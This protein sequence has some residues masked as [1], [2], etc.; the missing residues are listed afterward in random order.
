MVN[1]AFTQSYPRDSPFHGSCAV[2]GLGSRVCQNLKHTT[3]PDF[4]LRPE[5]VH[6][7]MGGFQTQDNYVNLTTGKYDC[8]GGRANMSPAEYRKKLKS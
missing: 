3:T 8:T 2:E 7:P 4:H 1:P 5:R 6:V